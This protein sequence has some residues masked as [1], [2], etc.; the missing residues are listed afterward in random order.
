MGL[1]G[2]TRAE[3]ARGCVTAA[4]AWLSSVQLP[5]L[6]EWDTPAIESWGSKTVTNA[7]PGPCRVLQAHISSEIDEMF[8][9]KPCCFDVV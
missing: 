6:E 2:T 1:A 9:V 7:K 5:W 4:A 8:P 3:L